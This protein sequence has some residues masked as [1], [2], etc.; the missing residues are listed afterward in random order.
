MIMFKRLWKRFVAYANRPMTEGQAGFGLGAV[1]MTERRVR[2][3]IERV[4]EER[5]N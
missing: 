5:K 2:A 1:P 3:I 4:L